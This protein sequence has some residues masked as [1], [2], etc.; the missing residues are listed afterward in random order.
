MATAQ[1]AACEF[2]EDC[3]LQDRNMAWQLSSSGTGGFPC[4]LARTSLFATNL[5]T[6]V[7]LLVA[8]IELYIITKADVP[9]GSSGA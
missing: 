7:K 2:S 4:F 3:A 5:P 1:I 8:V 6:S 9:E